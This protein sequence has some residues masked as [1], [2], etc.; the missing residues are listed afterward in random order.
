MCKHSGRAFVWVPILL[1][2]SGCGAPDEGTYSGKIGTKNVS[3]E[4]TK[5]APSPCKGTGKNL[6]VALMTG[7]LTRERI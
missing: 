6:S 5:K 2:F 4:V 3:I 7:E 1:L